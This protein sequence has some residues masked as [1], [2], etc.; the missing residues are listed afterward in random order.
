MTEF[1]QDINKTA[2]DITNAA[3]EAA[4]VAIGL[5]VIGLQR[6]QVAR[7]EIVEQL[8]RQRSAGAGQATEVRS[9][10]LKAWKEL[11]KVAGTVFERVD[12]TVEPVTDRLPEQAQL[13][14]KQMREARDQLRVYLAQQLAA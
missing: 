14:V 6:A 8:D 4:Y 5:G 11:D 9:Q 10:L 1:G 13:V 7:R 3:R 12:A 2:Q